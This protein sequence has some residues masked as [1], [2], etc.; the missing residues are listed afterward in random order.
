MGAGRLKKG[1]GLII[2]STERKLQKLRILVSLSHTWV[3]K[4][5]HTSAMIAACTD[6]CPTYAVLCCG[7]YS[8]YLPKIYIQHDIINV[9]LYLRRQLMS[10]CQISRFSNSGSIVPSNN[11]DIPGHAWSI[12]YSYALA[13]IVL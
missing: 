12:S 8:I 7:I 5:L 10:S 1:I 2:F 4:I 6:M 13:F 3:E 11:D 9:A